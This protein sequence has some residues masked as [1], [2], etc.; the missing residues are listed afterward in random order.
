MQNNPISGVFHIEL[1][2]LLTIFT[3]TF[4][5]HW[6]YLEKKQEKM[7]ISYTVSILNLRENVGL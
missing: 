3:T 1:S 5:E 4:P 7:R 6:Y 2:V